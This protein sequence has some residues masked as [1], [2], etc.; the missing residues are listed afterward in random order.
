MVAYDL[1]YLLQIAY[2]TLQFCCPFFK[3]DDLFYLIINFLLINELVTSFLM[4]AHHYSNYENNAVALKRCQ[5]P[6]FR[7]QSAPTEQKSFVHIQAMLLEYETW[8]S[9]IQQ[10]HVL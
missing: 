6:T 5:H 1:T 8:K 4:R 2:C 7:Q 3:E 9:N 10:T